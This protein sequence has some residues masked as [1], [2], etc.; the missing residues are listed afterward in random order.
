MGFNSNR[1][2]DKIDLLIPDEE[3]LTAYEKSQLEK[4]FILEE[5]MSEMGNNKEFSM[6]ALIGSVALLFVMLSIFGFK[7][8]F[9]NRIYELSRDI[10]SL[11]EEKNYLQEENSVLRMKL[12]KEKYLSEIES[13]I[14]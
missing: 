5:V 11:Q 13:E 8:H 7:I 3:E 10:N 1:V 12:E 6:N 2:I 14:F 9:N 4:E